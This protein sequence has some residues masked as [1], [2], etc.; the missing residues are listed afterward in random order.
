MVVQ[1]IVFIGKGK[2]MC[3]L[4]E[5]ASI[6]LYCAALVALT[7]CTL[8]FINWYFTKCKTKNSKKRKWKMS[9]ETT[10]LILMAGLFGL[11]KIRV[12]ENE[13]NSLK[14]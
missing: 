12:L 9:I 1:L 13:N 2:K 5:T 3:A 10:L 8:V 11:Y 6:A 4:T 7:I 14:R